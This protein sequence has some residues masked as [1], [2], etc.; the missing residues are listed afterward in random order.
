MMACDLRARQGAEV[1]GSETKTTDGESGTAEVVYCMANKPFMRSRPPHPPAEAGVSM[2]ASPGLMIRRGPQPHLPPCP[3]RACGCARW[4]GWIARAWPSP[5][6]VPSAAGYLDPAR[7]PGSRPV[8]PR[9]GS[10]RRPARADRRLRQPRRPLPGP[11]RRRCW[12]PPPAAGPRGAGLAAWP[13]RAAW[14]RVVLMSL[15]GFAA[16]LLAVARD[17]GRVRRAAVHMGAAAGR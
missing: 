13:G 12:P 3:A 8:T 1:H 14:P 2:G 17:P 10:L 15:W 4:R 9:T 16:G 7:W 6:A 5:T 11:V